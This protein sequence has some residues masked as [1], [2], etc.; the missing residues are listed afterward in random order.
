LLDSSS[1]KRASLAAGISVFV[2]LPCIAACSGPQG[3]A[4]PQG[5][6]G[7]AGPQGVPG[8][9]GPAGPQGPAGPVGPV[10]EGGI[11]VSCLSPCHG[12]NGVVSQFQTSVH[13]VAY[14]NNIGTSTAAEWTAPGAPC[15]N[16]HAIDALQ[17]R[18]TGQVG[19]SHDG[20]VVDL[21]SGELQ[22]SDPV[23]HALSSASYVGSAAVAEVY[24]TTCHA[25][26]D[27][28]DPHK[29][30]VPWTPG[31]FPLEVAED[32]GLFLEKS[33]SAGTVVGKNAGSYGPGNTCMWCH[34]SRVDVTN[35]IAPGGNKITST[36]WGPHEGP[37][38]DVFTGAGGYE[39]VGHTYGEATHQQKLSCVDC[40]M[41]SVADNSNVP[42]H[43]FNPTLA[44]CKTCHAT[45]TSY[46]IN[47]FQSQI[48]SAL[49]QMETWLNG[50]GLLTR[51]SAP[52]YTPLTSA[53]LGDGNWGTDQPVPG[54]TLDGGLLTQD[55]AGALYNYILVARGGAYGVHNPKYVAQLLYDS[56]YA[57]T[58]LPLS[59]FP[60]RP[61]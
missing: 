54:S 35:Y 37:Q 15:G 39:Y 9:A 8:T 22:Y 45:A 18:V 32:G 46:D 49:T 7:S 44:A 16:C 55:Q 12:F 5:E 26:T 13:Y 50:N 27:A 52:P 11:P 34:R 36:H 21:S 25:V 3:P 47:G 23:T 20:G 53:Q 43:S 48:K 4:G 14:L 17:Q 30:G 51:A 29:T 56:Y 60:Q 31:S 38:A 6:D 40:H 59:A 1:M 58:G 10:A 2:F 42:D 57:L 33:P 24:C 41:V 28:N 61:Q 19:T